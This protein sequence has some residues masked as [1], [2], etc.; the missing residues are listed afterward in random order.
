M[1]TAYNFSWKSFPNT[2]ISS[3]S[4]P[5]YLHTHTH[6][7]AQCLL[8]GQHHIALCPQEN[9]QPTAFLGMGTRVHDGKPSLFIAITTI[10]YL[11]TIQNWN[12]LS[13]GHLKC[14]GFIRLKCHH[15]QGTVSPCHTEGALLRWQAQHHLWQHPQHHQCLRYGL[16]DS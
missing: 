10:Y 2:P 5:I 13:L 16:R 1:Y 4:W 12:I 7:D 8:S 15:P 3:L 14:S 11:D 6:T 9:L